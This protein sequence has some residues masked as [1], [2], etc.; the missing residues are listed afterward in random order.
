MWAARQNVPRRRGCRREVNGPAITCGPRD[1]SRAEG[2]LGPRCR[3]PDLPGPSP[4]SSARRSS[5]SS[6]GSASSTPPRP[7]PM[8]PCSTRRRTSRRSGRCTGSS[9]P[10]ARSANAGTSDATPHRRLRRQAGHRARLAHHPCR[11]GHIDDLEAGRAPAR[12]PR[13]R[14]EPSRRHTSNDDP[15]SGA[16]FKTLKYRPEF[17]DRFGSIEDAR[18][19]RRGF[20]GW[21]LVQQAASKEFGVGAPG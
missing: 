9:P 7:R 8:P 5:I 16:G 20:S 21:P 18:A 1:D 4:R 12:R 13:D 14:Q 19:S 2:P 10:R 6:T 15:Y 17:P 11:P 3:A